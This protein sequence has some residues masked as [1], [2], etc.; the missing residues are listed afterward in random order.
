MITFFKQNSSKIYQFARLALISG[1]VFVLI[2]AVS[3]S[4]IVWLYKDSIKER[5]VNQINKG[6]Q[7]EVFI[8]DI[9]FNVF[10][11]FPFASIS[12]RNVT[13][14]E[15]PGREQRDTLLHAKRVYFQFSILDILRKN[16]LVKQAEIVD[17][18]MHMKIFDDASNNYTFWKS[19]PDKSDKDDGFEFRLQ[20]VL[21]S[22][23]KYTYADLSADHFLSFS[24]DKATV[25]GNFTR[26]NFLMSMNGDM[27]VN[28]II[29][30]K[31]FM[32]G[33][34]KMT[35]NMKADV[36]NNNVFNFREGIFT[37]GS[38][39]FNAHGSVD[40]SGD[41]V[42]VDLKIDAK[43]LKLEHVVSDL[44]PQYAKYFYGYKSDGQFYFN[45]SI[46][47]NFGLGIKPYV[48]ATFGIDGGTLYHRKA[49]L[50][51]NNISFDATF[52]N[53]SFRHLKSS[54]LV[55]DNLFANLNDGEI[56]GSARI[57]DFTQPNLD[58]KMYST[59]NANEWQRFLQI[60]KLQAASGEL[61]VDVEFKGKLGE[62]QQFTA[63]HFMASHVK[64][65][66]N[67]RDLSFQI[68]K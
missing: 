4:L 56:K 53:G 23:M 60:E 11:S 44:P 50:N 39:A 61:L 33:D 66:I 46:V 67:T 20:K 47:G 38:H 62:N 21:L 43:Q 14:L 1:L 13:M 64:G 26:D 22:Q 68:K 18:F 9:S 48:D 58:V 51:F 19:Q 36:I 5:F 45:A 49:N 59:I 24:V 29:I 30:D 57:S 37:L 55:I 25:G 40:L 8:E 35:F 3:L 10:R 42:Y 7:T 16:Y 28:E 2:M 52:N 34:R 41:D 54:T 17:G 65:V 15:T 31:A 27:L 12:L 32:V 6:L 63:Y